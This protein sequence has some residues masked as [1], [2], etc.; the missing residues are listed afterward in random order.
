MKPKYT[1]LLSPVRVGSHVLKNRFVSGNALPHFL[2]GPETYPAEPLINHVVSVARNGAAIVTIADWTNPQQ[3]ESFNED[4]RR[5]PMFDL[6][7]PSV[8]NYVAQMTDQIH[9]YD[10]LASLALMPF[11]GPDPLFDVSYIPAST[12]KG[13]LAAMWRKGQAAQP[14]SHEQIREI[15]ET[16]AQ[17]MKYY[18]T[19]GFDMCTLHFAY[20]A[21]LFARFLS[22]KTNHRTDEYG[23]SI[24][25]RARFMLELCQRI[26]ELCGRDF[27]IEIQISAHEDGGTTLEETI[28]LAKLAEGYVDIFQFRAATGNLNHPTGYNSEAHKYITLNECA[29]VKASGTRILCEPIGGFQNLEDAE[30]AIAEGKADLIGGARMFF[31]DPDFYQKALE[32]RGED[33]LPCVRCNKCHVLS[34][35]GEWH[36]VCTVNPQI[37]LAHR[38][39]KLIKPTSGSKKVAIIG[40]GPAGMRAALFCQERGHQVSLFEATDCLGGQLNLM[41][42]ISFKWPLVQYREYL[43]NQLNKSSVRVV[44]N[45]RV[46]PDMLTEDYDAVIAALGATPVKPPVPGVEK[47][48]STFE[49][50]GH[51]AELGHR[52]VVIGGSETG[53]D[54]GM[55]LAEKGH[56]VVVLTRG[57]VLAP[58]ATPIHYREI[59]EESYKAMPNFRYILHAA[60]QSIGDDFVEYLDTVSGEVKRLECDSVVALGGMSAHQEEAMTFYGIGQQ[61]F[62]IGDCKQ[63]GNVQTGN[64]SAYA[65]ANQI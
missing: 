19:L 34:M 64:R 8:E 52:C 38:L 2:Q 20:G 59:M 49:V 48:K 51:E 10:S 30:S 26:K 57:K 35:S 21:T 13:G 54:T 37:G 45:T 17:K 53:M 6:S 29:A 12:K 42:D 56:D 24:E 63:I 36:S 27:P 60:T 47:A 15:I 40:G 46:T 22:P 3:R 55:Y 14:F 58:D 23:G 44:M 33:V 9:Y 16:Y 61:F 32:G 25:N 28:Q 50:L 65:A 4:G 41:D 62:M 11:N 18:Q 43:K 7:D 39:D 5:F 1:H 31:V